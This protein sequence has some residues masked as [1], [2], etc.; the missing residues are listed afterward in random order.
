MAGGYWERRAVSVLWERLVGAGTRQLC[1]QGA[2]RLAYGGQEN[3]KNQGGKMTQSCGVLCPKT[4]GLVNSELRLIQFMARTEFCPSCKKIWHKTQIEGNTPL[5]SHLK[6]TQNKQTKI[7]PNVLTSFD[8]LSQ[9]K[10]CNDS[11]TA[12]A[13]SQGYCKLYLR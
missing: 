12:A 2:A 3:R 8:Y 9:V 4:D 13:T 5:T 10:Y 6:K 11:H 7:P 1:Q